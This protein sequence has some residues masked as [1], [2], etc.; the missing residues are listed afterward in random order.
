MGES[1]VLYGRIMPSCSVEELQK[2]R[3]CFYSRFLI[4]LLPS[5]RITVSQFVFLIKNPRFNF[6]ITSLTTSRSQDINL[7]YYFI[8]QDKNFTYYF[9][10]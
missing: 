1:E 3:L 6:S 10:I 2:I 9:P 5:N 8:R 4:I 7:H